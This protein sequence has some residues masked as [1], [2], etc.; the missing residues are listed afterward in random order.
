MSNSVWIV[1][2]VGV[3]VL[4]AIPIMAVLVGWIEN[5]RK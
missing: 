1:Y 5:R 3:T 2:I 4:L